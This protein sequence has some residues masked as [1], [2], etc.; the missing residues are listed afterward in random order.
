MPL[1]KPFYGKPWGGEKGEALARQL[2]WMRRGLY[3][4]GGQPLPLREEGHARG[5]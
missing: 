1:W 4:T 2:S 5:A 3:R